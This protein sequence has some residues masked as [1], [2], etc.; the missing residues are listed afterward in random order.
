MTVVQ[1]MNIGRQSQNVAQM[2]DAKMVSTI[3]GEQPKPISEFDAMYGF[4]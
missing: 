1:M 3:D 4:I 2:D